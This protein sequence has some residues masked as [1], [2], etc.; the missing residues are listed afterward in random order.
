MPERKLGELLI[1]N[2]IINER[3]LE[4]ILNEQAQLRDALPVIKLG[5]MLL[6]KGIITKEQLREVLD[7]QNNVRIEMIEKNHQM[8]TA[9]ENLKS[10]VVISD[11]RDH[12]EVAIYINKAFTEIT[13][14]TE[15][16]VL[17]KNCSFL[18]GE[19]TDLA[20]ALAIRNA[21][22][23]HD[24]IT[25][26]I[27]NYRKD[28]S[29]FWNEFSLSPVVN[30]AGELNYYVGLIND[31][32][33]R[34]EME[35]GLKGKEYLLRAVAEVNNLIL[36][37]I[38]QSEAINRALKIL[39]EATKVDRVYIFRN[40]TDEDTGDVYCNQIYEWVKEGVEPQID[41]PELQNLPYI[42]AGFGRWLSTLEQSGMISGSVAEFPREEQEILKAQDILSLLVVPIF[43]ERRLWGMIGFDDC[44]IGRPWSEGEMMILK[45]TAAGIGSAIKSRDDHLEILHAHELAE[46]A[47]KSKSEFL[48]NMSHEIR[49]PM[50]IILGMSELL[51]ATDLDATQREYV[52]I[53]NKSGKNLL[54]LINDILDLSKIEAHQIELYEQAFKI[55]D[56]VNEVIA[57]FK[58]KYN[59]KE[60]NLIEA[61]SPNVPAVIVADESRMRQILINLVGNALKFTHQG[62]VRL[63]VDGRQLS[64]DSVELIIQVIDTGI[65][66]EE[67]KLDKIFT[68]FSQADASTTKKYGGTGLGLTITQELIHLMGGTIK[69]ISQVGIGTTFTL[70]LTVSKGN[71]LAF[72]KKLPAID[73]VIRALVI[74]DRFENRLIFSNILNRY[75]IEVTDTKSGTEGLDLLKEAEQS[76][77]P[78]HIVLCDDR[79]PNMDGLAVVQA[80]RKE[81]SKE[82]LPIIIL[83]SDKNALNTNKYHLEQV[84]YVLEK[85][86]TPDVLKYKIAMALGQKMLEKKTK[87]QVI[88][89]APSVLVHEKK[90][91]EVSS[92]NKVDV[93]KK[94]N[95]LLLVDDVTD[96]RMLVKA[97][98]NKLDLIIDEAENGKEAVE[99]FKI[100]PYDLVLMDIQM[101]IQDG[102]EAT[103]EIRLY[104]AQSSIKPTPV[105][106][107][108]AY[109]Y[110]EEIRKSIDSGCTEHMTK[111]IKKKTLI[112]LIR[113]YMGE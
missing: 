102:Y 82:Y 107:L 1:E 89:K 31:V 3:D 87:I 70:D 37:N 49:T 43:V 6:D 75:E 38:N 67:G 108:S 109:A 11:L 58:M 45:S 66:I 77:E 42:E 47:T 73:Q 48:A 39:G 112:E 81:Y 79:M 9:M 76:G 110:E 35:E 22:D 29:K 44:T 14:Y 25:I 85:P 20:S 12:T 50:N 104:E 98:L 101:P 18:R 72:E 30:K 80:I 26:N 36:V 15:E 96:N 57:F 100:K 55:H 86:I 113:R 54:D 71:D 7:I 5:D 111:P 40:H 8:R 94:N 23:Q 17:G 83:S 99:M 16:E 41:S 105:I 103:R 56:L 53:F 46:K 13:G 90:Y 34:V 106:A 95:H 52:E 74:D 92:E 93:M 62:S 84:N 60:V 68:S 65:G 51:L 10:G 91:T 61:I 19:E 24:A 28:G 27:I 21:I 64:N 32:T 59:E 78:Y 97:F 4:E 63:V 2:S 88:D 33:Q 69:A